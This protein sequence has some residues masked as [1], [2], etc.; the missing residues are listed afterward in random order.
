[1]LNTPRGVFN[2]I[3]EGQRDA[4]VLMFS[5]SLGTTLDM[6]RSQV[7]AL[8]EHFCIVRYDT[9]GH[10]SSVVV[11]GACQI[12][13]LSED[14]I[15]IMDALELSRVNFCGLSMGGMIGLW[16]GIHAPAR[17]GRLVVANSAAQIAPP[18]LWND[19]IASVRAN[20]MS[21]IAEGVTQRW[22]TADFI[23]RAPDTVNAIKRM[24][25][26]TP[27]EGY[28]S[29]CT[30]VRDFD[31][32]SAMGVIAL[33]VLVIAGEADPATPPQLTQQ[34]AQAIPGS[35][36]EVL[37]AAHL[38]NIECPDAFNRLLADFLK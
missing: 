13:D 10:G 2:V 20:G 32:R 19:R 28:A 9:R 31:V 35:R 26:D 30:A 6:W 34:V 15:A 38:S 3:V 18:Q 33:P 24:I 7:A 12:A 36:F 11:P 17:I 23:A 21:A 8:D 1:M 27:V 22:F 14:T 37:P 5:N 25:V 4:P 16:L 29:C